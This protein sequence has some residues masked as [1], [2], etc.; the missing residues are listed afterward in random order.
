MT[1]CGCLLLVALLG[2]LLYLFT[3]GATD[4]GGEQVQQAIAL[5]LGLYVVIAGRRAFAS[6]ARS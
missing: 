2:F 3:F 1:G 5:A 6:A 4:T